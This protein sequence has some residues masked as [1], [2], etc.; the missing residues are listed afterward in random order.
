MDAEDAHEDH[1]MYN[2]FNPGRTG[3]GMWVSWLLSASM[4]DNEME[5]IFI[6]KQV[7]DFCRWFGCPKCNKDANAY[8]KKYPPEHHTSS[9]IDLFDWGLTFMNYVQTKTGRQTYNRDIMIAK[10]FDESKK[11]CN[12]VCDGK[13]TETVH[14]PTQKQGSTKFELIRH[15]A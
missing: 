12:G 15:K 5:R 14:V 9:S 4:S 3:T 11:T 2:F 8:L 10:F 1:V 6:C 13:K 7:R